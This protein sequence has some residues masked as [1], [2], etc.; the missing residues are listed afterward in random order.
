VPAPHVARC[1]LRPRLE[2]RRQYAVEGLGRVK[3][4][5]FALLFRAFPNAEISIDAAL[6]T[7]GAGNH[8]VSWPKEDMAQLG[9]VVLRKRV[10][11]RDDKDA[12]NGGAL[13][14]LAKVGVQRGVDSLEHVIVGFV[15]KNTGQKLGR[16]A[17]LLVTAA[18][19]RRR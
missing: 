14:H 11:L 10:N 18:P 3:D 9:I 6:Q 1:S 7:L 5:A 4:K 16:A 15:Q 19:V 2:V 13:F 12:R 8:Q 17:I